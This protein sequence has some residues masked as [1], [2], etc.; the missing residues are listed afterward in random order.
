MLD[1]RG[2]CFEIKN[3]LAHLEIRA[4]RSAPFKCPLEDYVLV[5][6][7]NSFHLLSMLAND[8]VWLTRHTMHDERIRMT[9]KKELHTRTQS[10][11]QQNAT[12]RDR[13][14][15]TEQTTTQKKTQN[16]NK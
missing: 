2:H 10:A 14:Q 7:N 3:R 12:E 11:I 4:D 15:E 5:Q 8:C 16:V 1:D 9:A 6:I 13:K